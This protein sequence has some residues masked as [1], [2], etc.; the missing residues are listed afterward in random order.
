MGLDVVGISGE[1]NQMQHRRLGVALRDLG[2]TFGVDVFLARYQGEQ[3][4][5]LIVDLVESA[6]NE[7]FKLH[8]VLNVI[9]KPEEGSFLREG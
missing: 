8:D 7:G 4:V 2:Y 6:L 9:C 1:S 5:D 3:S